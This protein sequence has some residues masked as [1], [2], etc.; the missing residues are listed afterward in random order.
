MCVDESTG[1]KRIL[2]RSNSKH[3]PHSRNNAISHSV[4]KEKIEEKQIHCD[5][6]VQGSS[7]YG[8]GLQTFHR[9]WD[10]SHEIALFRII[11][12]IFLQHQRTGISDDRF[13]KVSEGKRDRL[14][15]YQFTDEFL[16]FGRFHTV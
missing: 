12:F 14:A 7:C 1:D 9:N 2:Q 5:G 13:R 6:A 4:R 15:G 3:V 10:L 11:V 8:R 16:N